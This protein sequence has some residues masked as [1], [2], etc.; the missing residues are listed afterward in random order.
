[1]YINGSPK[2]WV[3]VSRSFSFLLSGGHDTIMIL[4]VDNLH[5]SNLLPLSIF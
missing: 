5:F 2:R 3:D 4:H 1:V